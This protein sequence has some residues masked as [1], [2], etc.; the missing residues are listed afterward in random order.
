MIKEST[1]IKNHRPLYNKAL[2]RAT[3]NFGLFSE[4]DK[5]G[6]INFTIR[7]N[8][9]FETP[10]SSFSNMVEGREELFRLVEKFDL[11]QKLSGLY[12]TDKNKPCCNVELKSCKG[13]CIGSE[14]TLDYNLKADNLIN[15]VNPKGQNLIIIDKGRNDLEKSIVQIHN[16]EYIGWNYVSIHKITDIESLKNSIIIQKND[17]D[18]QK[19]IQSFIVKHK[20]EDII[21]Y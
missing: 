21:F 9:I 17:K 2:K 7:P 1:E 19:L 16:N 10:L 14:S 20:V 4:I 11:C 6:Y 18:I 3:T 8:S 13:A 12:K 15:F 5:N